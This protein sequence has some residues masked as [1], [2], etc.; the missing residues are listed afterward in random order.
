MENDV[1][2]TIE[3]YPDYEV[4]SNGRVRNKN[5]NR[6]LKI[7]KGVGGYDRVRLYKNKKGKNELVHRLVAH[8]FIPNPEG[9]PIIN[10]KDENPL[11]NDL[12]NLEWCTYAYNNSYGDAAKKKGKANSKKVCQIGIDG[13][14]IRIFNSL[15]EASDVLHLQEPHIS[16]CCNHL[17]KTTGGYAWSFYEGGD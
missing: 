9:Y 1:W 14:L 8:A 15:R 13:T 5:T 2:K 12:S 17:R 11:N 16:K 7:R 6:V 3:Q 10:H 4:S